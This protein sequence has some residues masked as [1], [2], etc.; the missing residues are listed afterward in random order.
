M[1]QQNHERSSNLFRRSGS[2]ANFDVSHYRC[3]WEV[4]PAVRFITGKVT[5]SFKITSPA[6]FISLDLRNELTVDSVKQRNNKLVFQHS[7]HILRAN[8]PAQLNTGAIDSITIF[9]KGIPTTTG[10]GSFIQTTHIG[11]PI[12]WTLSEPY[13]SMDWWPC[14]NGLDDKADSIDIL[15]THPAQFKAASNGLMQ[16]E[17]LMPGGLKKITHW[18]HRYPIA[19]YLVAFAVTNYVVFDRYVQ[20][21]ATNLLMQTHCYPESLLNFQ[22]NTPNVLEA[23]SLFHNH[24]GDYPFIKEKYG[25]VQ[26]NWG[27][28]ME[29]QT[30]T[31]ISSTDESLMAHELGHQ[32]F[33]D[34]ITCASWEDIWLNEGFATHLARMHMEKKYPASILSNRRAGINVITSIQGGSVKVD[35][36]TSVNRIFDGRLS[37]LKGSQLLYMLRW[38]LGDA[39][40]FEAVRNYM[41]DPALKYGFA[42]T[43]DLK[44]HLEKTSGQNLTEFFNDWYTGQGYPRYNVQWAQFGSTSVKIKMSQIPSHPSVSFFEMPVALKFKNATNERTVVVDNT[45]NGQEFFKTIGF[46][47]DTVLIDPEYWLISANNSTEKVASIGPLVTGVNIYPNPFQSNISV[48]LSNVPASKAELKLFNALGQL[49]YQQSL[50]LING[51]EY[52]EIKNPVLSSGT[53]WM[54]ISDGK[55]FNFTKK[56]LKL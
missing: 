46:V 23:M 1:E 30:A 25:H 41:A 6:T 40:F 3:E 54:K 31:F 20:L 49:V 24:F 28:G 21:G 16:S 43:V 8:F 17:T 48:L 42:R 47:A 5:P 34:K 55:D 53:Y 26:W 22:Q 13:G 15:V 10:F 12:I 18:K 9:Y 32:W 36:T 38:K 33:G 51:T 35:D 4:N 44:L 37:Y 11:T 27:G 39:K 50:Q 29:H 52:L 7:S 2:S 14:K 56:L 45:S 19:S